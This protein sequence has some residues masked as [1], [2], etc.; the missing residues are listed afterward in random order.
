MISTSPAF[1][2]TARMPISSDSS[3]RVPSYSN[4][5]P[6]RSPVNSPKSPVS[7][8][9]SARVRRRSASEK[10]GSWSDASQPRGE[11]RVALG[12][13]CHSSGAPGEGYGY[14]YGWV[15]GYG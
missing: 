14:G 8:Y 11:S 3:G 6:H 7:G 12:G 4:T 1:G 13:S 15:Q 10:P 2:Q 5:S 9:W